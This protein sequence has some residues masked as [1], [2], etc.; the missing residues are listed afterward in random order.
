MPMLT[1]DLK[2][3]GSMT[4]ARSVPAQ[5]EIRKSSEVSLAAPNGGMGATPAPLI[6]EPP[7]EPE[8][9]SPEVSDVSEALEASKPE[10]QQA[11]ETRQVQSEPA[12][13]SEAGPQSSV[14]SHLIELII[15]SL[16]RHELIEAIPFTVESLGDKVFTATVSALNLVGTGNTLGDALIVVK[17]QIELLYEQLLKALELDTDQKIYLE[18]LQSHIKDS[19]AGEPRHSKRSFWR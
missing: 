2:S 9:A 5:R 14:E 13:A 7:S 19:S 6:D 8:V 15:D 17:E 16:P 10:L 18:Y 12:T 4:F 3:A 1:F 11:A